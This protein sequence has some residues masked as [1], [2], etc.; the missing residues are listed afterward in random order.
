MERNFEQ[1]FRGGNADW[2]VGVTEYPDGVLQRKTGWKF[3]NK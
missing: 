1:G 3:R 2:M